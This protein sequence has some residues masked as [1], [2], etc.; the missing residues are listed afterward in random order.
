MAQRGSTAEQPRGGQKA[1]KAGKARKKRAKNA[2]E[3]EDS[4][5]TVAAI[6][7]ADRDREIYTEWLSGKAPSTIALKHDIKPRRVHEVVAD[8]QRAST[9]VLGRAPLREALREMDGMLLQMEYAVQQA[10]EILERAMEK[11]DL[12]AAIGALR[13]QADRRRELF[14]MRQERG[15]IP[16]NL[17]VLAD[18]E[19]GQ[20][21][22]NTVLRVFEMHGI[23]DDVAQ[24]IADLI[25]MDVSTEGGRLQLAERSD[26][27]DEPEVV[28]GRSLP[29]GRTGPGAT[30]VAQ[31]AASRLAVS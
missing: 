14:E 29:G 30:E 24:E 23:G 20:A 17:Q 6:V 19:D 11:D 21:F 31:A 22:V 7:R 13:A 1:S 16:K 4:N 10:A 15:L 27:D 25:E 12:S 3:R 2:P 8:L 5:P 9:S 18:Q 28:D 26:Y